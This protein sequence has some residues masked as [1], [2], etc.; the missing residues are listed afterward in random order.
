MKLKIEMPTPE[1]RLRLAHLAGILGSALEPMVFFLFANRITHQFYSEDKF[2]LLIDIIIC[3]F[4]IY[5]FSYKWRKFRWSKYNIKTNIIS[6]IGL[7]VIP[8]VLGV[9]SSH[10]IQL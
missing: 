3:I 2:L 7:E 4:M 6:I 10:F 9:V 1:E 8:A 5:Q